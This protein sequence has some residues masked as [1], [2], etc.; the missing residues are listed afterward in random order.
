MY[1][2]KKVDIRNSFKESDDKLYLG[3]VAWVCL[4]LCLMHFSMLFI[5]GNVLVQEGGN[6]S[7]LEGE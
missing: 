5:G 7:P 6:P 4:G 1:R 3:L 2:S